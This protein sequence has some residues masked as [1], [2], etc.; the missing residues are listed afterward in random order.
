MSDGDLLAVLETRAMA[1]ERAGAEMAAA[2]AAACAGAPAPKS[3][4]SWRCAAPCQTGAPGRVRRRSSG[5]KVSPWRRTAC[6]ASADIMPQRDAWLETRET[7]Q[8]RRMPQ[9]TATKGGP[10]RAGQQHSHTAAQRHVR[11]ALKLR[12]ACLH[13]AHMPYTGCLLLAIHNSRSLAGYGKKR[14]TP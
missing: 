2:A 7:T 5:R 11:S 8:R 10:A 12:T 9:S 14:E 4:P 3:P 1:K 6:C 13:D